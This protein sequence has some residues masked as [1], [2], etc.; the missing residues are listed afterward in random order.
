V[1]NSDNQDRESALREFID[2]P[3]LV[4]SEAP[5]PGE[6]PF[7]NSTGKRLFGE[8][9]NYLKDPETFVSRDLS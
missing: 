9:V 5:K 7:E 8:T 2:D 6:L 1:A 3:V 4:D